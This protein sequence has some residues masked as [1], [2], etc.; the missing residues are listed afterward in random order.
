MEATTLRRCIGSERYGIPA[1]E[2]PVAEF[3]LQPSQKDGIGR[4]CKPHWT[5]YTRGLRRDQVARAAGQTAAAAEPTAKDEAKQARSVAAEASVKKAK[6]ARKPKAAKAP[7][8]KQTAD[9][10][11]LRKARALLTRTEKLGG[12]AYL[13]AVASDPV[14]DALRLVASTSS[15]PEVH[16]ALHERFIE[17]KAEVEAA[18]DADR[19]GAAQADGV[20]QHEYA[21][22]PLGET[23]DSGTEEADA[24]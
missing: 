9:S 24:A 23:I 15:G 8:A 2:A 4:M 22:A 19:G 17:V 5:D 1:H 18:E 6:A 20:L 12:R 21:E 16:E 10:A 13:D 11:A 3:P 7:T 14:Q